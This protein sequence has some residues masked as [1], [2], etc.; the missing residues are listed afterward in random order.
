[1]YWKTKASPNVAT[2]VQR[3]PCDGRNTQTNQSLA[4][5]R[6]EPK[7]HSFNTIV[8]AKN[9]YDF[10][11]DIYAK[12]RA[13]GQR[14]LYISPC[15]IF[16]FSGG[17]FFYQHENLNTRC[18]ELLAKYLG[19]RDWG[20]REFSFNMSFKSSL[21]FMRLLCSRDIMKIIFVKAH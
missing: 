15:K 14:R 5:W 18:R 11:I 7:R 3:N 4:L 16:E 6:P 2:T 21:K 1:M 9:K 17:A 20:I 8:S 10:L 19:F 12:H 13:S